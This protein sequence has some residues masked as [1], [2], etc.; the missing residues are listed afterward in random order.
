MVKEIDEQLDDAKA[1]ISE[2]EALNEINNAEIKA[3]QAKIVFLNL[4]GAHI[5]NQMNKSM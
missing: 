4:K 5:V 1:R 2:L 3:L